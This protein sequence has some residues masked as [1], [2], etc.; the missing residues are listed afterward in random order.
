MRVLEGS[1]WRIEENGIELE[2]FFRLL[3]EISLTDGDDFQ[4][5]P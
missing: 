2:A 5:A 4:M 1:L 3:E